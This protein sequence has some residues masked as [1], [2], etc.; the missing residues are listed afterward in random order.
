MA[1][2]TT[3]STERGTSARGSRFDDIA[4]VSGVVFVLSIIASMVLVGD[5]PT[6]SD[7]AAAISSYLNDNVGSHQAGLVV[8]SPVARSQYS[9]TRSNDRVTV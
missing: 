8:I 4:A 6:A 3:I 1:T 7:D 9:P 5:M 2:N